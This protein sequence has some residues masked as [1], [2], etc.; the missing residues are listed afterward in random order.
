MRM[1]SKP[2]VNVLIVDVVEKI[3]I[4]SDAERGRTAAP[5]D[6]EAAVG[7]NFRKITDRSS[8]SDNV[9]VTD[10]TAPAAAGRQKNQAGQKSDRYLI[11]N[12][13]VADETTRPGGLDSTI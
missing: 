5:F 7:L 1:Q 2:V 11:H 6:F 12:S 3:F 10:D 8:V 13:N 9:A 4:G